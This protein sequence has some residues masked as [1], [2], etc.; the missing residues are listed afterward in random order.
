MWGTEF[1]PA[2]M[3]SSNTL[4]HELFPSQYQDKADI[5]EGLAAIPAIDIIASYTKS[6]ALSWFSYLYRNDYPSVYL[7]T[8]FDNNLS[9]GNFNK[10]QPI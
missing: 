1:L 6:K 5:W 3:E 7:N 9:L 4:G 10:S 8:D 2:L